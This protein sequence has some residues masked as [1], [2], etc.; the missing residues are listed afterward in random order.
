MRWMFV[1]LGCMLALNGTVAW[2]LRQQIATGYGDFAIFYTAGKILGSGQ[3]LRL[4]DSGLQFE[5][6]Q[7]FAPGV[8]TRQNGPL[9]YNH[10]PF[11]ALIFW[12]MAKLSYVTAFDVWTGLNLGALLVAILVLRRRI[13]WLQSRSAGVWLVVALVFFPVSITLLQGQDSLW[14]LLLF[15]LAYVSIERDEEFAAGCWLGVG[16][17]RPQI[18]LPVMLLFALRRRWRLWGGFGLVA[19]GLAGLSVAIVGWRAALGYPEFVLRVDQNSAG[20]SKTWGMPNLHGLVDSLLA[21]FGVSEL[22]VSI[23]T[24]LLS[25]AMLWIVARSCSSGLSDRFDVAFSLMILAAILVSYHL[26]E[27]DLSLL[28]VPC[29][30]I[31][32][33]VSRHR[34][35]VRLRAG[36]IAPMLVLFFTPLYVSLSLQIRQ[37]SLLALVLMAWGAALARA[38]DRRA[39]REPAARFT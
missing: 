19:A 9:P 39:P 6:Q 15:A 2:Y 1:Y 10:P 24:V 36:L 32:N 37:T 35:E 33:W 14:L 22:F 4:Y 25:V 31:A 21:G 27:H 16:L 3:R 29:A 12:P 7:R 8:T 13:Q 20:V 17:F 23:L 38:L 28:L 18:V 26:L 5:V 34:M 11:E 30:L